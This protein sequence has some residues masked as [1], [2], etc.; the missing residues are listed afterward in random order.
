VRSNEYLLPMHEKE[1][2]EFILGGG[3]PGIP[4]ALFGVKKNYLES[5]FAEVYRRYG[6]IERYFSEGLKINSK[7]Q[8][9]LQDLYLVVLSHQ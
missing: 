2:S 7:Q 3:D 6:T 4:D 8:Q 1:S 5:S 9:Q